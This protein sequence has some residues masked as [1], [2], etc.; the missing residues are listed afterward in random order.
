MEQPIGIR[1]PKEI[2]RKIEEL[3]KKQME[4]R[5]TI[6]RKLVILG[7]V[8]L[9]KEKAAQEYIQGKI[10]LTEG[11][12]QANLTVWEMERYLIEQGFKSEYSVEDLESELKMLK[13]K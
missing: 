7:Y 10:T 6:I 11:A 5:S 8:K 12:R 2:M 9:M 4:D 3:S 13:K 1:L